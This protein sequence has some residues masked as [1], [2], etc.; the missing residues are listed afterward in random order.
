VSLFRKASSN[1]Q[2]VD[3]AS[4]DRRGE[5]DDHGKDEAESG[6][7]IPSRRTRAYISE[8]D[9]MLDD[10]RTRFESSF[11]PFIDPWMNAGRSTLGMPQIRHAFTDLVDAGSEYRVMVEAPGIPK[12]NLDITVTNRDVKIEGESQGGDYTKGS[13]QTGYVRRERSYSRIQTS[14][15]FPEEVLPDTAEATLV[16]GILQ[17]RVAKKLPTEPKRRKVQ[18]T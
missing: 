14:L 6:L 10:F 11:L 12:E 4:D 16:N 7:D 1:L 9:R 18:V 15:T 3:L 8:L 5:E 17:V 13:T 2:E